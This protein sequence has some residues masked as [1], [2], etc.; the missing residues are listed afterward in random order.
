MDNMV[1]NNQIVA[2]PSLVQGVHV[3]YSPFS[4]DS[5]II[6]GLAIT[7]L[8]A[9]YHELQSPLRLSN[10]AK[11]NRPLWKNLYLVHRALGPFRPRYGFGTKAPE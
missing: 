8:C 3:N 6:G 9:C 4:P 1:N 10:S 7:M 2:E 5:V 11:K